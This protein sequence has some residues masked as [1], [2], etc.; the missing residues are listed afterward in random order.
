MPDETEK[1]P[2]LSPVAIKG[3]TPD[4]SGNR[5]TGYSRNLPDLHG[6]TS[7]KDASGHHPSDQRLALHPGVIRPDSSLPATALQYRAVRSALCRPFAALQHAPSLAE[8]RR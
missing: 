1:S 3:G 6:A 7:S 2:D 8:P 5:C 4:E